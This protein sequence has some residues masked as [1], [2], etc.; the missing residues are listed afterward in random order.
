MTTPTGRT[1]RCHRA[2]GCLPGVRI[3]PLRAQTSGFCA[4]TGSAA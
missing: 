4:G 2:L 3:H 1:G